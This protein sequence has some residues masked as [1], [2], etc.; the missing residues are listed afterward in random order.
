MRLFLIKM[1]LFTLVSFGFAYGLDYMVEEGIKELNFL[2]TEKWQEITQG[3]IDAEILI[4]GSSR[5]LDHF[6]A[7]YIE[8]KLG[9]ITYNLGFDGITFMQEKLILDLYLMQN[10]APE[11]LIWSLD[12]HNFRTD[13]N[14]E[15]LDQMIPFR[16]FD[17][18]YR[19]MRYSDLHFVEFFIPLYRYSITPTL[20]IQGLLGYLGIHHREKSMIKGFRPRNKTW[21]QTLFEQQLAEHPKGTIIDL[22]EEMFNEFVA[23]NHQLQNQGIAQAWVLCPYF[24]EYNTM[25]LNRSQILSKIQDASSKLN[26]PFQD[27]SDHPISKDNSNFYNRSH[28]NI[29]G[30][31]KFMIELLDRPL[32]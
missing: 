2:E 14:V 3:G 29:V 30:V 7:Q 4:V 24:A 26:I 5:A 12:Y 17:Q 23:L 27:F 10:K 25:V 18:V 28:M 6:D 11:Y 20:K 16:E 21:N 13:E 1:V 8:S 22:E 19:L 15:N 32:F 31:K 9:K